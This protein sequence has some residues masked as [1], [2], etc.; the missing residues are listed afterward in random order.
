MSENI[1]ITRE[2][3]V[4]ELSQIADEIGQL[5]QA[6]EKGAG[7]DEMLERIGR[8]RTALNEA[9]KAILQHYIAHRIEAAVSTG[10]SDETAHDISGLLGR[11]L[12][13]S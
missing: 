11:T 13:S 12:S 7:Y 10:Y 8:A 6:W 9:K 5:K 4:A 3:I 1:V 2:A